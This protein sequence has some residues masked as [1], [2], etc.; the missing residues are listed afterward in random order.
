MSRGLGRGRGLPDARLRGWIAKLPPR[1][2]VFAVNETTAAFIAR[3]AQAAG[4]SIPRE[5]T[6]VGVGAVVN[7][8]NA[9]PI[10]KH[11]W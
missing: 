10:H 5:L 8:S 6:L 1:T 7:I 11:L 3:A 9:W 4:R 2:A